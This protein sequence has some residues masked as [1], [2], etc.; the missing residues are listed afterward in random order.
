ML[1]QQCIGALRKLSDQGTISPEQKRLLLTDIISSS[2][3]GECSMVEVAYELLCGEIDD[4]EET[5]EEEFADQCRVLA[6]S[7]RNESLKN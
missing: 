1:R 6:T 2:A 3:K 4:D 5:A 7:L